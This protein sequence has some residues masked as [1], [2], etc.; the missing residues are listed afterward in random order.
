MKNW[1]FHGA[2]VWCSQKAPIFRGKCHIAKA[3]QSKCPFLDVNFDLHQ[4]NPA[5]LLILL[6]RVCS[7]RELLMEP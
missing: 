3:K 2:M 6:V 4:Q 1:I 5:E 7:K